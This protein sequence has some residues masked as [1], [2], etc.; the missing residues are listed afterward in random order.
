MESNKI[1]LKKLESIGNWNSWKFQLKI[2][3]QAADLY[4]IVSGDILRPTRIGE[5]DANFDMQIKE[6][7]KKDVNAK[8]L[9]STS[10]GEQPLA[11]IMSCENS[12]QMWDKLHA[13]YEQNSK[14]QLHLL[15]QRFYSYQ[16]LDNH[17]IAA[18]LAAIENLARSINA[19]GE[20]IADSMIITKI[21]ITLPKEFNHFQ[22][23][24][25]STA[26]NGKTLENLTNRLIMEETRL[27]MQ[28][29]QEESMKPR[30]YYNNQRSTEVKPRDD[31][32][33]CFRCGKSGHI[34]RFCPSKNENKRELSFYVS[35]FALVSDDNEDDGWYLDTGASRH[36]CKNREMF[37]E[38]EKFVEPVPVTVG[39]GSVIFAEGKGKVL[40]QISL[41]DCRA[42][43]DNVLYVP[44]IKIN[45]FSPNNVLD[46]GY[47]MITKSEICEFYLEDKRVM[48]AKKSSN[49]LFKLCIEVA[50]ES[51]CLI[52]RT[53]RKQNIRVWH[54][55]LAHQNINQVR[56]VL[57]T[58]EIDFIDVKDFFCDAC[59]IGKMHRLPFKEAKETGCYPGEIIVLDL[60]TDFQCE[61]IGGNR[62]YVI[63]KDLFS[64]Y[65]KVLFL[66]A[67]SEVIDEL[68]NIIL[69]I[70][71]ESG[72][73]IKIMRSDNAPELTSRS[74]ESIL[75]KFGICH[76]TSCPQ[77]PQQNGSAEREIRT[78]TELAR[79]MLHA[80]KMDYSFWAEAVHT[81][82]FVLNRSGPSRLSGKSPF[83]IWFKKRP[84]VYFLKVFG[85]DA[86]V[87]IP[88]CKRKK[89]DPKARKGVF[90]GYSETSKG[91]RIYFEDTET[92]EV[93]RNVVFPRET[94]LFYASSIEINTEE[95]KVDIREDLLKSVNMDE[96]VELN[97]HFVV[98]FEVHNIPE[99]N[100]IAEENIT[101]ESDLVE[102]EDHIS[103]RNSYFEVNIPEGNEL[104]EKDI[105]E[106]NEIAEKDI[107]VERGSV[108][109]KDYTPEIS[110]FDSLVSDN[111]LE[112][113]GE[114][115]NFRNLLEDIKKNDGS[116]YERPKRLTKPPAWM[117]D[118]HCYIATSGEPPVHV[119]DA[120]INPHWKLAMEEEMMSLLKNQTWELVSLP[121]GK[122]IIDNKWIFTEKR[123]S[124]GEIER[125]KAR[126]VVR[127]FT[128]RYGID[129]EE[130]FSPVAR[131]ESIRILLALAAAR[132]M[133]LSQFDVKTAFLN[134][135]LEEEIYMKQPEGFEDGSNR[136]CKLKRSLYGL[137]QSPRC[138]NQKFTQF[139]IEYGFK[140]SDADSCIFYKESENS[141]IYLAIYVDDGL[142]ASHDQ[143]EMEDLLKY[144]NDR[145]EI[146]VGDFDLFLGLQIKKYLDGS[147][148]I[149]QT[150]YTKKI[151]MKY[152]ME[153]CNSCVIPSENNGNKPMN[154]SKSEE[155]LF[156]YR[157][158]VGSL[159]YLAIGSRPD[160]AYIVNHMSQ[161]N[162]N[163]S[164]NDRTAL[165][166][167]FRYLQGTKDYGLFYSSN[168]EFR[169]NGYS[170]SDFAGDITT[171]KSRSGVLIQIGDAT[172]SWCSK[173]Q[174]SV[175][176]STT[177]AEFVAAS[178]C[179]RNLIWVN[180]LY[181]ELTPELQCHKPVM[182]IDNQSTIKLIKNPEFHS[183]TKH[184]DIRVHF[185]RD[186]F[187]TDGFTL[188]YIN[189]KD[190]K[191]DILTKG[192]PKTQF[193]KLREDIGVLKC[194]VG[195]L[196]DCI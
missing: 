17:D 37:T 169:I 23:A 128:Q 176:I 60:C 86:F 195:M 77:T 13:V 89:L 130:T 47:K 40:I 119:T 153:N 51:L 158:A 33:K 180:R 107:T 154:E 10:I 85:S 191:A 65:K 48:I 58:M 19:L 22:S 18:H 73:K 38:Y 99:R 54:E 31:N 131:M 87:H 88:D 155:I 64:K 45:L 29:N 74:F 147:L 152:G 189:T 42:H 72:N 162:E 188:F 50:R 71:T 165:K 148:F 24:W 97:E 95:G 93:S 120:L 179:V 151:L 177:E 118:Y 126:L 157:E 160:I 43:L 110:S 55:R 139:L 90:V 170:D 134:G 16:K 114:L 166:R 115:E 143:K 100:E 124:N 28:A 108:E 36:M 121:T 111:C 94:S 9:I 171:R 142:V 184:I 20:P 8:M 136:V 63:F 116:K 1:A 5:G 196:K 140:V 53:T 163:P 173:K 14:M 137:K 129:Y 76:Q 68:E 168:N 39:D 61:S 122:N 81:A 92:V 172:V 123:K 164:S 69:S 103:E 132:G 117:D 194:K 66:K 101:A 21:L 104:A 12:K 6:W 3:L 133:K 26:D 62:H 159:M 135:D 52:S 127:G 46:K 150:T 56:T 79:T 27:K 102:I 175:A 96:K 4:G 192:L 32:R 125:Y 106:R 78:V 30:A 91:Y 41:N 178:E 83:E 11:Y 183:R 190:Q 105:P 182:Y 161:F 82:C 98:D 59:M 144:L 70:E 34:Q 7:D 141:M 193:L 15:Q 138:W 167:I 57:K 84:S 149:H 75:K 156:P 44:K 49:Q 181:K 187:E 80:K 25:E 174:V 67:R 109:I 112:A 185:I 186:I 35:A 146:K 145:F 113:C 2:V